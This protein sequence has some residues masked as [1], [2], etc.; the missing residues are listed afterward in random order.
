MVCR[1]GVKELRVR[2][3]RKKQLT[4]VRRTQKRT[5]LSFMR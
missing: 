3:K 4:A 2:L 5:G 1:C